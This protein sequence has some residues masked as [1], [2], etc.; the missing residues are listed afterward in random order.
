MMNIL[1][2]VLQILGFVGLILGYSKKNR[3][4]ML[5]GGLLLWL[6]ASLSDFTRGFLAG[7][8]GQ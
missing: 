5:I 6:G 4:I 1:A 2:L 7:L 3:N 8:H